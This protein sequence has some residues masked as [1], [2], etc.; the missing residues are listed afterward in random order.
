MNGAMMPVEIKTRIFFL[1]LIAPIISSAND[2]SEIPQKI[3][4]SAIE[5]IDVVDTKQLK[6]MIDKKADFLLL[7]VR[8]DPDMCCKQQIDAPRQMKLPNG[9]L[10]MMQLYGQLSNI[11]TPV[12]IYCDYGIKSAFATDTMNQM[13][14]TNVWNYSDGFIVWKSRGYPVRYYSDS[15]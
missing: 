14:F 5:R 2:N 7:D 15:D 4:N 8:A 10:N 3:I 1:L 6:E 13:G 9:F 12:V 11:D